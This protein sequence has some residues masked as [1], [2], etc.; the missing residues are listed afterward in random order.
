VLISRRSF[1]IPGFSSLRTASRIT[2]VER[3]K[4][5]ALE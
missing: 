2:V 4:T 5:H 3:L 1:P